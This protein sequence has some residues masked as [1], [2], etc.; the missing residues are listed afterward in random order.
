AGVAIAFADAAAHVARTEG[1][2][3]VALSGGVFQNGVLLEAVSKRLASAGYA[4]M[5][6]T[7]VPANDGGLAFGQAAVA[8]ARLLADLELANMKT[9][10]ALS[11]WAGK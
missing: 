3:H 1:L 7:E 8:A 9:G 4:V 2:R 10:H 5:A 11:A 6:P